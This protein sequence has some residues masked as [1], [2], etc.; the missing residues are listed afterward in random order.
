MLPFVSW[1]Y[2]TWQDFT[3][4]VKGRNTIAASLIL[5]RYPQQRHQHNNKFCLSKAVLEF[6]HKAGTKRRITT[7]IFYRI[8]SACFY[9]EILVAHMITMLK[10]NLLNKHDIIINKKLPELVEQVH[11]TI[12]YNPALIF[13]VNIFVRFHFLAE[14]KTNQYQTQ[15]WTETDNLR[16]FFNFLMKNFPQSGLSGQ[17]KHFI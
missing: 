17:L 9:R 10:Q 15:F 4:P 13:K 5:L 7:S 12:R 11:K 6:Y 14:H 8:I 16:L 1:D 2:L 3:A